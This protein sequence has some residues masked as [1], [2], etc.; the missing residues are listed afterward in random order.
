M[1]TCQFDSDLPHKKRDVRMVISFFVLG[2]SENI[3]QGKDEVGGKKEGCGAGSG[4]A[5]A[6]GA[7]ICDISG[8]SA[9][10]AESYIEV[11]VAA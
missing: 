9:P 10:K 4:D 2:I 1:R 11:E 3:V 8:V 7:R 6:A 5:A